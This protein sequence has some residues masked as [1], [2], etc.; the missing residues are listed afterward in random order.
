MVVASL[1]TKAFATVTE[2]AELCQMSRSRFYDLI[3][4]GV[5]PK[6]L[7]HPSSKRPIY[8]RTLIEKCLS[9]RST[10]IGANNL[11]VLF[12]RK[13][14]KMAP[15][16]APQSTVPDWLLD[17]LKGLDL[18]ATQQ[19]VGEAIN[20]LFPTGI[21]GQDQADVVRKVFLHLQARKK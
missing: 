12:N 9:I 11:P 21:A 4:S 17:A 13:A 14:K 10:G 3:E 15:K 6:P 8:D 19:S 5:F 16:K 18:S 1:S 2:V 20:T 7:Q